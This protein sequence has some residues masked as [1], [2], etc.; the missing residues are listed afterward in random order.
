LPPT[1]LDKFERWSRGALNAAAIF[2]GVA[3]IAWVEMRRKRARA[4][5]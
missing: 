3:F 4:G 1:I 5:S 2:I